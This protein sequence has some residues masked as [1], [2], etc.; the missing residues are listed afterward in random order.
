MI[1]PKYTTYCQEKKVYLPNSFSMLREV[2][3]CQ[4]IYGLCKLLQD[5]AARSEW[6][7]PL[8]LPTGIVPAGSE[9][10]PKVLN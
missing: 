5:A 4:V 2:V 8:V 3:A 6:D 9:R 10:A 1:I 7:I